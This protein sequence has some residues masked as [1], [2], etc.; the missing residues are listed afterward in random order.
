MRDERASTS[1][2]YSLLSTPYSGMRDERA[3]TTKPYSLLSTPYSG[4]RDAPIA[5][6]GGMKG[7]VP[8]N[9]TL[10]SL[11]STPYSG[12]RDEK[13][14]GQFRGSAPNSTPYTPVWPGASLS[15]GQTGRTGYTLLPT[16]YSLLP[17]PYSLLPTP[18]YFY[19]WLHSNYY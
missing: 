16:P 11:L 15:G 1:K 17:T 12:M 14:T 6:G 8:P 19:L 7:L 10:Y 5:I 13:H 18:I 2:P 4:M 9:P 3:S